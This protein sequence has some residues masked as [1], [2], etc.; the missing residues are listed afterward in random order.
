MATVGT[1]TSSAPS[2]PSARH[3]VAYRCVC[4]AAAALRT[5]LKTRDS[6][7]SKLAPASSRRDNS[8]TPAVLSLCRTT[9]ELRRPEED[10]TLAS[11]TAKGNRIS[12][13]DADRESSAVCWIAPSKS[14]GWTS[15]PSRRRRRCSRANEAL[16]S[17]TTTASDSIR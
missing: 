13:V 2:G 7:A 10:A 16:A 15:V 6:N 14:A 9:T 3:A 5:A 1:S 17:R 11:P 4:A 12:F 8:H